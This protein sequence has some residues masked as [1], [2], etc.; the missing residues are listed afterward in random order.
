M[1]ATLRSSRTEANLRAAFTR[2]AADNRRYL[3][4]ARRADVE[5]RSELA[6][7]FR[8]VA[9]GETGHAFGHLEFLEEVPDASSGLMLGN[10]ETNLE[11]AVAVATA[12]YQDRY[13]RLAA[14]AREEGLEEIAEWFEVCARARQRHAQALAQALQRMREPSPA[15]TRVHLRQ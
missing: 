13:P 1:V 14:I 15:E 2:E 11:A 8:E 4:F 7:M 12:D 3:Y 10:T 6:A 9:E 5:G